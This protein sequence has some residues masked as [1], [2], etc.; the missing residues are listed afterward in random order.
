MVYHFADRDIKIT[1]A[2][3]F[4]RLSQEESIERG[5]HIN[6][7]NRLHEFAAFHKIPFKSE[8]EYFFEAVPGDLIEFD[9]RFK[10]LIEKLATKRCDALIALHP[11]RLSRDTFLSAW[12]HRIVVRNHIGLLFVDFPTFDVESLSGEDWYL[13]AALQAHR[14]KKS[15]SRR[16]NSS[17]PYRHKSGYSVGGQAPF[18]FQ[19]VDA[20]VQDRRRPVKRLEINDEEATVIKLIFRLFLSHKRYRVVTRILNEKGYRTRVTEGKK[21]TKWSCSTIKRILR[22]PLYM[23]RWVRNR[24]KQVRRYEKLACGKMGA[25]A[26]KKDERDWIALQ[27]DPIILPEQWE[28]AQEVMKGIYFKQPRVKVTFL[29][30]GMHCGKCGNGRLYGHRNSKTKDGLRRRIGTAKYRCQNRD[31]PCDFSI[32]VEALDN[33]ILADLK[34]ITNNAEYFK[35]LEQS[36]E[37]DLRLKSNLTYEIEQ[38]TTSLEALDKKIEKT[39][40]LMSKK[41]LSEKTGQQQLFK[42]EEQ[43][44]QQEKEILEKKEQL[45]RITTYNDYVLFLNQDFQWVL[46]QLYKFPKEKQ[47]EILKILIHE[48]TV[49]PDKI[50]IALNYLPGLKAKITEKAPATSSLPMPFGIQTTSTRKAFSMPLLLNAPAGSI[51]NVIEVAPCKPKP[52]GYLV[53]VSTFKDLLKR[54]R[55]DKDHD[56]RQ[57]AEAIGADVTTFRLWEWGETVPRP[58]FWMKLR[59]YIGTKSVDDL[60]RQIIEKPFTLKKAAEIIGISTWTLIDWIECNKIKKPEKSIGSQEFIFSKQEIEDLKIR[61]NNITCSVT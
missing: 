56:Q 10:E 30:S 61:N 7:R 32:S 6:H 22:E 33:K 52:D 31:K 54:S 27:V 57:A 28:A 45:S 13:S 19:W 25:Y 36:C 26:E 4:D 8:N 48:I 38:T 43:K 59:E 51:P 42:M 21:S 9:P 14:E 41:A 50:Q 34:N 1:N 18:G 24:L 2:I 53:V 58:E 46:S 20:R 60:S 44:A 23:G 37:E 40:E 3:L 55:M 16:L 5:S 47:A 11:D 35:H 29:F 15:A 39:I 12:I 49:S 17:L